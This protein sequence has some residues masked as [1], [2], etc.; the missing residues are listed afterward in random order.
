MGT[1]PPE[2]LPPP[3][4]EVDALVAAGAPGPDNPL[5]VAAVFWTAATEP[6]GPDLTILDVV[7]TPESWSTW[8][9]FGRVATFLPE[10]VMAPV[11]TPAVGDP[12]VVYVR[13][14]LD[15]GD[16]MPAATDAVLVGE[17]IVA[18]LV[19]RPRLGGWRVHA[20]GEHVRPERVPRDPEG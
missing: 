17:L 14:L 3:A 6:D 10:Y 13:F 7:V 1:L 11:A 19:R 15:T 16:P 18:T 5:T 8:G 9:G 2:D 12:D 4:S 20:L